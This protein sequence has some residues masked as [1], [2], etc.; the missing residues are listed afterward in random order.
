M[1]DHRRVNE[2]EL[3]IDVDVAFYPSSRV[4]EL[5]WSGS[6]VKEIG[7]IRLCQPIGTVAPG[8][9]QTS[10]KPAFHS[11]RLTFL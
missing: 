5:H 10:T 7:G 11:A 9:G 1:F 2:S 4:L 3:L 8:I 6:S